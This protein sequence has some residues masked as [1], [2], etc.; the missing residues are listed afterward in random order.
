VQVGRERRVERPERSKEGIA[1]LP[2]KVT[3]HEE[4]VEGIAGLS[5]S[6]LEL[7]SGRVDARRNDHDLLRWHAVIANEGVPSPAGPRD[8]VTGG[9]ERPQIQTLLESLDEPAARAVAIGGAHRIVLKRS[10]IQ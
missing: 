8:H 9:S 7:P 1:A 2:V 6:A 5:K 10:G 4:D 3:P